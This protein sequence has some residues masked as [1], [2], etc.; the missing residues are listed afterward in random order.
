M[1]NQVTNPAKEP[2]YK[3][4]EKG[5]SLFHLE[6]PIL[7]HAS[8]DNGGFEHATSISTRYDLADDPSGAKTAIEAIC[9]AAVEPN[10]SGEHANM[11]RLQTAGSTTGTPICTASSGSI[12]MGLALASR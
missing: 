4:S 3:V 7:N 10:N 8:D 9:D 11:R 1:A 6:S 5:A 2:I 12:S